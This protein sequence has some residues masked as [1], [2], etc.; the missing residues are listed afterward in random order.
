MNIQKWT[1]AFLVI[2]L[3]LAFGCAPQ[4]A[5]VSPSPLLPK[6]AV[7][8]PSQP[9][10]GAT[11]KLP[12]QTPAKP[13]W[14]EQWDKM[15][16]AA[17]NEG[18]V[19]LYS[20]AGSDVRLALGNVVK[21]KY[22]L[23]LEWVVGNGTELAQKTNQERRAGLYLSDMWM[24]G[25]D[26]QVTQL[27]PEGILDPLRPAL[28]LPEVVDTKLWYSGKLP[29]ADKEDRYVLSSLLYP[30]S[31]V[32]INTDMVKVEDVKSY[33]NLLEPK[34]KGKI[35]I[36][37]PT[38]PGTGGKW[39]LVMLVGNIVDVEYMRQLI[40]QEP[41][42]IRDQRQQVE[43]V[44]RGKYPIAIGA[45][46]DV[47]AE[48]QKSG[49]PIKWVTPVEGTDLTGGSGLISLINQA[50]HPNATRVFINWYLSKEGQT[51]YSKI[52]LAQSARIDV[53]VDHISPEMVR[54]PAAKYFSSDAEDFLLKGKD[55]YKLARELFGPLLK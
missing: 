12:T 2:L 7:A 20:N 19:V 38:L 51:I 1:G 24:L 54:D 32:I 50:P 29:F 40:S 6:T 48:F 35:A 33:R 34:W 31:P 53:P 28:L 27:K 42:V 22:G 52:K 55:H 47:V 13:A 15:V 11:A 14:Q 17:K 25:A 18:K 37:D 26:I 44:A 41:L 10:P 23:G 4:T 5:P 8:T 21:E 46:P 43:W 30:N 16:A 9:A 39:G 45:K 3:L 36:H 49:A